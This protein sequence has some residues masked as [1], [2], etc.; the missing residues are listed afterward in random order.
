MVITRQIRL[1]LGHRHQLWRSLISTLKQH[2]LFT[3]GVMALQS[4]IAI[5]AVETFRVGIGQQKLHF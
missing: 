5:E 4:A 2:Q 3:R 1:I